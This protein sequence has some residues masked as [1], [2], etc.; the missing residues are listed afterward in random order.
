[1]KH[2]KFPLATKTNGE[3]RRFKVA[4][5]NIGSQN[6]DNIIINNLLVTAIIGILYT[7][8]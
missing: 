8:T 5:K 4:F 3:Y 7:F 6:V 2:Q 1:M